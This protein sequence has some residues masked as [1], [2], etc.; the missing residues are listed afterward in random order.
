M[1]KRTVYHSISLVVAVVFMFISCGS[2]GGEVYVPWSESGAP[3]RIKI[4]LQNTDQSE[5]LLYF[6]LLL[7]LTPSIVNYSDFTFSGLD[8]RFVDNEE[9]GYLPYE[10]DTWNPSG[11]SYIWVRVPEIWGNS[12]ND[13]IYMYYGDPAASADTQDPDTLWEGYFMVYHFNEA[14][15]TISDSSP[16]A[17]DGASKTS[18]AVDIAAELQPGKIGNA[19]R[20]ERAATGTKRYVRT[21][22]D[23]WMA[24]WTIEAWVKADNAPQNSAG[25]TNGVM[26][27]H[28]IYNITWD[29]SGTSAATLQVKDAKSTPAWKEISFGSGLT[30]G[31]WYY[32]SGVFDPEWPPRLEAYVNGELVDS[33]GTL[34]GVLEDPSDPFLCLGTESNENFSLDAL[35]DEVRITT[36]GRS[37]EYIRAQYLNMNGQFTSF[38]SV[39]NQE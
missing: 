23:L 17:Y 35:I 4:T 38:G 5:N 36:R 16:W 7:H 24:I 32:L 11:D 27:F 25:Y 30:G 26:K 33:T 8:I 6:P 21:S 22:F 12:S 20:T 28:T 29:H 3:K 1:T 18:G 37:P 2:G 9:E 34:S 14:A 39:E 19:I 15:T 31:Q 10:I 13:Y